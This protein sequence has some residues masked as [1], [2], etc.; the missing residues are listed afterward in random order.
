MLYSTV[1]F[2]RFLFLLDSTL[3]LTLSTDWAS[4]IQLHDKISCSTYL[5]LKVGGN[6]STLLYYLPLQEEINQ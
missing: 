1:Y 3:I 5:S 6:Q 4:L 2:Y